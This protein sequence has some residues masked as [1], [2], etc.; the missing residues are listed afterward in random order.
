MSLRF[1][2]R[3]LWIVTAEV[4][5][6]LTLLLA[7]GALFGFG[8]HVAMIRADIDATL[9]GLEGTEAG[10]PAVADARR[11]AE[12]VAARDVRSDVIVV[13]VDRTSHAVVYKRGRLEPRPVV[14][15]RPFGD[16]HADPHATGALAQPILGLATAVGLAS[17]HARVGNVDVFV[18]SNDVALVRTATS[19]LV[20]VAL[21]W[22]V[23]L[24]LSYAVSRV[25]TSQL[26][27][28]LRDVTAAL[29]RFA[30][31]D[32]TPQ[33]IVTD[34]REEFGSLA[35]AYN[36]AIAQ[37]ERA[38]G[39]RDRANAAMRQ[40]VAD[41]GHQ[42][43]TPLTV[44]R[45]FI[46]ILRK[47]ELRSQADGERILATMARQS[48][49]MGTLIEKLM[50]LDAWEREPSGTRA[51]PIDVAQLAIDVAYPIA[52]A[53]P[54]RVVRVDAT[55]G[56]L[57]AIDP[58]ELGHAIT[59]LLDNALK[60]TD[61]DIDVRVRADGANVTVTVADEGPGMAADEV[62]HVFDRFY[63]GARREVEGSGL[64]LPIAKRAI[65]RAGGSI[66][67][68]TDPGAGTTFAI[69][70]PQVAGARRLP[71]AA[72]PAVALP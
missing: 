9:D 32:L 37:M 19:Y 14:A 68:Q 72:Q 64:G 55:A 7:A 48:V 12:A 23:L 38:F 42:L 15:V 10:T 18:R 50:L 63:R 16:T 58:S 6:V 56:P 22:F 70:L 29:E 62:A 27:R 67:I 13:A 20:P 40:F 66:G 53:H 8:V 46:A 24:G 21:V 45:G 69:R 5:V 59:N 57:A 28:P 71:A 31:G 35:A 3:L 34:R 47:G 54:V 61:G 60:Y 2:R 17:E 1:G 39:E 36:G 41:A 65:E 26:L 30:S 25:L 51:E 43:R 11:F 52:E 33:P 49:V 4:A 44:I